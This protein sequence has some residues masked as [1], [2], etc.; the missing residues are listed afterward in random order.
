MRLLNIQK[1]EQHCMIDDLL[2]RYSLGSAWKGYQVRPVPEVLTEANK[3][4]IQSRQRKQALDCGS[5]LV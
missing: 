5:R 1:K 3:S 2:Q 4:E